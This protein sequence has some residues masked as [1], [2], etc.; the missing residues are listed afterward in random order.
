MVE[1]VDTPD[2]KSCGSNTVRVRFPPWAQKPPIGGF[3]ILWYN[4][5]TNSS[6][7]HNMKKGKGKSI[8]AIGI[9]VG[10]ICFA[11][12]MFVLSEV[13]IVGIVLRG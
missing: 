8:L 6:N 2:L 1:L 10:F 4:L 5:D 3:C 13:G 7:N 9:L 11:A 12:I